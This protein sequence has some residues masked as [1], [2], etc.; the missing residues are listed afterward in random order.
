MK[1]TGEKGLGDI[2]QTLSPICFYFGIIILIALPFVLQIFGLNLNAS[3]FIIYPNGMVLL[4]IVNKFIQLFD[5][6]K[7][8]NP[9]CEKNVKILKNASKASWV[10]S[11]SLDS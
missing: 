4:I 9:F 5:S 6:L 1:I 11:N 10:R 8:N 3:L 2:L 7:K